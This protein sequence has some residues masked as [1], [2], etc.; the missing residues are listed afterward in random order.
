MEIV[1]AASE[2]KTTAI[3]PGTGIPVSPEPT[4]KKNTDLIRS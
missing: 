1:K 3:R 2:E 4:G